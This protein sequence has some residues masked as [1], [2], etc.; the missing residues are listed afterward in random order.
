MVGGSCV[1]ERDVVE[2]SLAHGLPKYWRPET[3][4]DAPEAVTIVLALKTSR[5]GEVRSRW[6]G[7]NSSQ[8]GVQSSLTT[9]SIIGLSTAG[10]NPTW[11]LDR[12]GISTEISGTLSPE[13]EVCCSLTIYS[14]V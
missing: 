3:S 5:N 8:R 14:W 7:N 1:A 10:C 9:P 13:D 2:D 12:D 6:G 11:A 4:E